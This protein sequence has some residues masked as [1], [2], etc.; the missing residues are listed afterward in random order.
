MTCVEIVTHGAVS[1]VNAMVTFKG[2]SLAVGFRTHVIAEP[3]DTITL[4][5]D[6]P[7]VREAVYVSLHH[8][9]E[10]RG[11]KVKVFS[12]IPPAK[13][14]K[15]SSSVAVGTVAAVLHAFRYKPSITTILRL[16]IE[17]SYRAKVTVTGALDDASA[18]LLGGLT[19][20]DNKM[21]RVLKRYTPRGLSAV[22]LIPEG[23]RLSAEVDLSRLTLYR[24]LLT[25]A[26]TLA[27]NREYLDAMN[28]NGIVCGHAFGIGLE[29]A[30]SALE[31]GASA[32]SISGK[33]PAVAALC[34]RSCISSVVSALKKYG[35][36]KILPIINRR[37][38][39][40]RIEG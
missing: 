1:I 5:P 8:L 9:G 30:T 7:L 3:R 19:V 37:Y 33:G 10:V 6:T 2:A 18:C 38:E 24:N 27:L 31:A 28:L 32:A 35:E 15:S 25:H 12:E 34:R 22:V 40:H 17:A 29:E 4:S 39:V 26:H 16:A 20:T 11:V 21:N 13:G 36:V 23:E 14:L